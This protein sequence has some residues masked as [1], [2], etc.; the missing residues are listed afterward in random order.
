[1]A[2]KKKAA[3][4]SVVPRGRVKNKG[5][6]PVT[7]GPTIPVAFRLSV[8]LGKRIEM[9]RLASAEDLTRTQAI[10]RLIRRGLEDEE[11][12]MRK[13]SDEDAARRAGVGPVDQEK[14]G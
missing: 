10:E 6:R 13:L 5:G 2:K 7:R 12:E 4:R 9:L 11:A 8:E 14:I 3:K 1:M